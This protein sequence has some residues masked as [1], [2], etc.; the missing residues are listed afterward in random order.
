[1][2]LGTDKITLLKIIFTFTY[3]FVYVRT[4]H[5]VLS[6]RFYFFS[7]FK[8][9]LILVMHLSYLTTYFSKLK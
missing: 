3:L 2:H 5:N 8:R 6:K 4:L 9:S 1:M 7:V